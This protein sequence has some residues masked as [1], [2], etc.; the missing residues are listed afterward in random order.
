MKPIIASLD[1]P[2][3]EKY[4]LDK[5]RDVAQKYQVPGVPCYILVDEEGK[6]LDIILGITTKE[7]LEELIAR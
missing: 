5:D 2:N 3:V 4:D 1:S 6:E 7:D